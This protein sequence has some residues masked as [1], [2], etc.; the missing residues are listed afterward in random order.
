VFFSAND[1]LTGT[2]GWVSDGTATATLL[3]NDIRPG[4][5]VIH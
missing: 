1:G 3:V 4:G 5:D 2:E